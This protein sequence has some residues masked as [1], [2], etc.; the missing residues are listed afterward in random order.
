MFLWQSQNACFV[1]QC[2]WET[3][4]CILMYKR[5]SLRVFRLHT[6]LLFCE[7]MTSCGASGLLGRCLISWK[8]LP[9]SQLVRSG[10]EYIWTQCSQPGELNDRRAREREETVKLACDL[11]PGYVA[12]TWRLRSAH[13]PNVLWWLSVC[14]CV[15]RPGRVSG[16]IEQGSVSGSI[17][18]GRVHGPIKPGRVSG[19]I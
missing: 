7:F 1:K 3:A 5:D 10:E 4:G 8:T 18:A 14:V 15:C 11:V 9:A 6:E 13:T 12:Y 17:K 19:P 2:E 16:P